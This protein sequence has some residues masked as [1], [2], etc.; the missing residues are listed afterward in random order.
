MPPLVTLTTDFG[1]RDPYVAAMK[2]VVM[3]GCP[4]VQVVDLSHQIAPHD[5]LEGAL[6]IACAI[7]CFA[8]GSIHVVVVDPGVGTG[9]HAMVV[10]AGGHVVVCPDNGLVTLLLR[11]LPL[12]EAY[13]ISQPEFMETPVSATFHGR[14]VFAPA[15]ARFACGS[16]LNEAGPPLAAPVLL[17]I[18]EARVDA[19]GCVRGRVIHVDHFGNAITNISRAALGPRTPVEALAGGLRIGCFGQTYGDV[20]PGEPLMLF[21][22]CDHLEIAVNC[23]SARDLLGIQRGDSVEVA[24][25]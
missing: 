9:R 13:V 4:G 19:D 18:P 7:P 8:R 10:R 23:R 2:G 21:G 24:T 3:A 15:A 5:V 1:G 22:S 25:A 12:E 11:R 20:A 14:D 17:D 6:F 16:P